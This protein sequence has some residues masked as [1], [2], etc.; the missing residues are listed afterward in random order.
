MFG[1][2][3]GTV[4]RREA[5]WL[6]GCNH[7]DDSQHMYWEWNYNSRYDKEHIGLLLP[8]MLLK[9]HNNY[10]EIRGLKTFVPV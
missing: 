6:S 2:Q 1:I 5:D 4:L 8:H 10:Q 7:S 9:E 3:S